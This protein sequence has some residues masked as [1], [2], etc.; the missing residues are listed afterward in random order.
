MA[1]ETPKKSEA[2]TFENCKSNVILKI[3]VVPKAAFVY[4]SVDDLKM[5]IDFVKAEP[6]AKIIEGKL[7]L[8]YGKANLFDNCVVLLSEVGK[9]SEVLTLDEA[10]KRYEIA[11][12]K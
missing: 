1:T 9:V 12:Q 6:K 8:A 2:V 5:L 11:A 10:E 7:T 4:R 3:K